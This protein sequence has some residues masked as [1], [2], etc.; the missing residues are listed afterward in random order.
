M[1]TVNFRPG[2]TIKVHQR[3]QEGDKTRTQIFQGTVLGIKGRGENRS[4]MVRK[5]SGGIAVERIW[6]VASPALEKVELV[7]N[8]KKRVKRA[9]LYHL[10]NTK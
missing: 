1:I 9:K 4:F 2:D 5:L 3:I 7:A 8:P 6:P 10:R